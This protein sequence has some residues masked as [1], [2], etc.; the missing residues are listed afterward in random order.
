M[1]RVEWEK[2][3]L[4]QRR[5]YLEKPGQKINK[6]LV[7]SAKTRIMLGDSSNGKKDGHIVKFISAE[8]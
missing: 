7:W 4:G 8:G 2:R 5:T 6:S 1:A 3:L